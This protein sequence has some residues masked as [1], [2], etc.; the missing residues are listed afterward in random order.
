MGRAIIRE[1]KVLWTIEIMCLRVR[2]VWCK[3]EEIGHKT[4]IRPWTRKIC[5]L[6][7]FHKILRMSRKS[8]QIGISNKDRELIQATVVQCL[9]IFRGQLKIQKMVNKR[10]TENML[11]K[12]WITLLWISTDRAV[13]HSLLV[14]EV[15]PGF[16]EMSM[17]IALVMMMRTKM[18][19]Q[20]PAKKKTW[21]LTEDNKW[22]PAWI[23][24]LLVLMGTPRET[25]TI[26]S[27]IILGKTVRIDSKAI[28]CRTILMKMT[29]SFPWVKRRI[30]STTL[31]GIRHWVQ[32]LR[33][34]PRE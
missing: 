2:W 13:N 21:T 5:I 22:K 17:N 7:T 1:F 18:G 10:K 14:P 34:K 27:K 29:M 8:Y 19:P 25:L 20:T 30:C 24:E 31:I 4:L 26:R 12:T 23:W 15:I 28:P 16:K 33:P 9:L 32:L 3:T 6:V 11:S